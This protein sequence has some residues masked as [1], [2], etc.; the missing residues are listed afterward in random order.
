MIDE[1]TR[2]SGRRMAH[3]PASSARRNPNARRR[4][5]RQ[6]L[7]V[8]GAVSV[9]ELSELLNAS[10]NTIRRDL[11][12]L[13]REGVA[14]RGHGGATPRAQKPAEEALAIRELRNVEEKRA[15]AR[16]AVQQVKPGDTVF[17]NDGSTV[18]ALAR[19]LAAA[20]IEL[21]VVTP[22]VDVANVLVESPL[23]TVC[24]LGGIVR[25]TSLATG[26]TFAETVL[27]Q[28]NADVA[29]LSADAFGIADGM[30]FAKADDA[31]LTRK[32]AARARRCVA[33]LA[34]PKFGDVARV[35]GVSVS[36]IDMLITDSLPHAMS[37]PLD[38]AGVSVVVAQLPELK[39]VGE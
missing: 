33:M 15:I 12:V 21:F 2:G 39:A 34:S 5:L 25:R 6:E 14:E 20:Q 32:M 17:L 27:G 3:G 22:A 28:F 1:S 18:M 4:K 36:Q 16:A 31:M 7:A 9:V 13:T 11:D 10:S 29:L 19:E 24:L 37:A 8:R 30:S 38:A 35:A 23:L 26:G